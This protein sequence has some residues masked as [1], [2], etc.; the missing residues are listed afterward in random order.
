MAATLRDTLQSLRESSGLDMVAVVGSDGLLVDSS[1]AP[2]VDAESLSALA[3]SGLLMM[4]AVGR[5]IRQG[6]AKQA[7]LEYDQSLVVLTPLDDELLLVAIAHG[8]ANLG[9]IRLVL[10]RALPDVSSAVGSL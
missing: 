5:E 9:R 3:A 7:I 1:H 8:E 4:D 10:R 2:D 6:R